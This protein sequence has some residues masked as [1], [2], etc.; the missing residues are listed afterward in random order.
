MSD[1]PPT[2]KIRR[3]YQPT[4][5][6]MAEL[7]GEL[8]RS[9]GEETP[10]ALVD[11]SSGEFATYYPSDIGEMV[12]EDSSLGITFDLSKGGRAMA[13]RDTFEY[14]RYTGNHDAFG[15]VI[16]VF[17]PE[18]VDLDSATDVNQMCRFACGETDPSVEYELMPGPIPH[19]SMCGRDQ[20]SL[21]SASDDSFITTWKGS[22]ML[23]LCVQQVCV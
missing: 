6:D 19:V 10:F 18:S 2:K 13:P 23:L 21:C 20:I 4:L 7:F 1:A 12:D 16:I 9:H 17:G 3:E 8:V 15:E 11:T 14:R 22:Y 5:G